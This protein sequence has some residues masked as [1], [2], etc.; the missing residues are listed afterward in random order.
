MSALKKVLLLLFVLLGVAVLAWGLNSYRSITRGPTLP[1]P[2]EA[3]AGKGQGEAGQVTTGTAT[4]TQNPLDGPFKTVNPFLLASEVET[5]RSWRDTRASA[6]ATESVAKSIELEGIIFEK[7]K[8]LAILNGEMIAEGSEFLFNGTRVKLLQVAPNRVVF[9]IGNRDLKRELIN[10]FYSNWPEKRQQ[11]S[12][13]PPEQGYID[14]G[15]KIA[16]QQRQG[17]ARPAEIKA[18]P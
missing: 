1:S 7:D 3:T 12:A 17:L 9:R 14:T 8:P 13:R 2:E 5:G 18:K 16:P 15:R 4:T 10:I 6:D 11:E